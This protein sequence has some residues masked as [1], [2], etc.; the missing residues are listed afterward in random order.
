M[1]KCGLFQVFW[2]KNGHKLFETDRILMTQK[3]S[4]WSL[5]LLDLTEMDFGNYS[6]TA[7]NKEGTS[8]AYNQLNGK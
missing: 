7:N 8:K 4:R 1:T 5:K 6:C 3:T 2:Y